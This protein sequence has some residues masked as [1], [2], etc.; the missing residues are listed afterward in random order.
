MV[1]SSAVVGS[2]AISSAGAQTSAMAIMTRWRMPPDSLWGY[3]STRSRGEAILTRASISMTADAGGLGGQ[4][5]MAHQGFGN[6]VADREARIERGHR[7][8]EDHGQAVAAQI[9]HL[10]L[11]EAGQLASFEQDRP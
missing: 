7:L 2:S 9:L 3:S 4:P 10:P 6:L 11:G 1:T 5:A 8:L